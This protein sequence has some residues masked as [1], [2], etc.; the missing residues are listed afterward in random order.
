MVLG[1]WLGALHAG[2]AQHY[3]LQYFNQE[4]RLSARSNGTMLEDEQGYLWTSSFRG[5][6]RFDGRNFM[7]FHSGSNA[8]V[9]VG[10]EDIGSLY[11]LNNGAFVYLQSRA[12]IGLFD[13]KT[14]QVR[15]ISFADLLP[16]NPIIVSINEQGGNVYICLESSAGIAAIKYDGLE[17]SIILRQEMLR[18]DAIDMRSES[19]PKL[20]IVPYAEEE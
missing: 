4:D 9:R 6:T 5:L 3:E 18:T 8:D 19:R 7:T 14:F 17:M 15:S 11:K 13:P 12:D 1:F 10:F 16:G 2:I 20:F